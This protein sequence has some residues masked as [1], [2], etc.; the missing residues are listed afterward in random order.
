MY[1]DDKTINFL[2]YI[3]RVKNDIVIDIIIKNKDRYN[4]VPGYDYKIGD[5][6][7]TNYIENECNN[8]LWMKSKIDEY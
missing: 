7:D 6:I 8:E 3:I 4:C 2:D 1:Y 5:K